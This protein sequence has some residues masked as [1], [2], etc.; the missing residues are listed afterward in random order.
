MDARHGCRVFPRLLL[1]QR[2]GVRE[3]R[4]RAVRRTD[5]RRVSWRDPPRESSIREADRAREK[6]ACPRLSRVVAAATYRYTRQLGLSV[7]PAQ[8]RGFPARMLILR[9][10]KRCA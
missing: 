9:S 6:F 5:R 4:L 3:P 7:R 2:R 10:G 1:R 8:R